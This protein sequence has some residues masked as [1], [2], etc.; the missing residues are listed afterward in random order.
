MKLQIILFLCIL[1]NNFIIGYKVSISRWKW[2]LIPFWLTQ[3]Y[4]KKNN[5]NFI[6]FFTNNQIDNG[7]LN[8]RLIVNL[9]N[10]GQLLGSIGYTAW[11]SRTIFQF[12]N[13]P[14]AESPSGSRRFEAPVP[15]GPWKGI[16]NAQIYGIQCPRLEI[17]DEIK[18][19]EGENVDVEDCLNVAIFSTS[20]GIIHVCG[21]SIKTVTI[22]SICFCFQFSVE[23]LTSSDGFP[24]WRF[25]CQP[26]HQPISTKLFVGTRHCFGSCWIPCRCI[27]CD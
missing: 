1:S 8:H 12:L 15:I 25:L 16:R 21:T 17:L 2:I 9:P 20:V 22:I 24:S 27:W 14:Y 10:Y 3:N 18:Q 26:G 11:T 7:N 6:T 4:L 5:L 23:C 13:V 19:K